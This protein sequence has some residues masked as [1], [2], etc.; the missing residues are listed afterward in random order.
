[1]SVEED[2]G[3]NSHLFSFKLRKYENIIVEFLLDIAESKRV[4]PKI[5]TISSYLLIHGKLTQKELKKLTGFSMGSISTLLSVM[6]GTG[7][8][9]KE[10]IP[11]THTYLYS[12]PGNLE[13]LTTKGIE[14]ALSSFGSLERYLKN[15]KKQLNIFKKQSKE[16][17]EH[18]L[19]RID[20]LLETFEA[21][22]VLFPR[23]VLNPNDESEKNNETEEFILTKMKESKPRKIKFDPEVYIIE[24]DMLNQLAAS[25][26][27]SSRDPMFI[28]ILGYF[29]TRKYLTQK[30]LQ[31][32][33]GLSAGKISEEVNL[34]LENGLIEKADVSDKGK[35]TYGAESAGVLFLKFSRSIISKMVKWEKTLQQMSL[36]L[37]TNRGK[38]EN[39]DGYSRIYKMND[40]LLESISSYKRFIGMVDKIIKV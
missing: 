4:N 23:M 34:L 28:R 16:G 8:Y 17:S 15:K 21:Y 39:L 29:I 33:T 1:M 10:R 36:E 5:S 6:I 30:T 24:D 19:Q 32:V 27:F 40:F 38:L 26:M 25:P 31:R 37:N 9:K 18:L 20:E 7:A 3:I 13:D 11:H 35:I 12:F 14:I 2:L 22:K